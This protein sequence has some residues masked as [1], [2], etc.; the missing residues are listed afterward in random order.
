MKVHAWHID[1]NGIE[2][3]NTIKYPY[4]IGIKKMDTSST[5]VSTTLL[6]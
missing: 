4:P 1:P 2:Y 5:L 3:K 6:L